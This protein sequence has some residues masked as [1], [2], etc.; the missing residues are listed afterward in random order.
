M[1]PDETW[2]YGLVCKIG[3]CELSSLSGFIIIISAINMAI[4]VVYPIFRQTHIDKKWWVRHWKSPERTFPWAPG[5]VCSSISSRIIKWDISRTFTW[6]IKYQAFLGSPNRM[7]FTNAQDVISQHLVSNSILLS[8]EADLW[9]PLGSAW[10][11]RLKRLWILPEIMRSTGSV[12][13]GA[14][15]PRWGGPALGHVQR[16]VSNLG[17]FWSDWMRQNTPRPRQ[18]RW[19]FD[20]QV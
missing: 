17:A 8:F 20:P 7:I 16:A 14:G 4:L 6:Y 15:G 18:D 19:D 5:G 10:L 1:Y 3:T 11:H 13:I 12:R 2:G 9:M